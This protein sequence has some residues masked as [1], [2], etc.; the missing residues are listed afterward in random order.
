MK[1]YFLLG[2]L[3]GLILFGCNSEKPKKET[4]TRQTPKETVQQSSSTIKVG[5][6]P[7]ALFLTP[8]ENFLYVANV[9]DD[10][11]SV[12]DTKEEKVVN[13]IEGIKYPWG[14]SRLGNSNLVAVSG[15]DKQIVVIDFKE[16][17]IVK[18]KTFDNNLG[19]ITSTEDGK[20]IYVIETGKIK[21]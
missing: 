17:K 13:K 9:E 2:I 19:G 12:I 14:F 18:E 1:K 5:K 16:H 3:I 11:L 20:Y 7:D 21:R 4:K 15:Y 8:D 10:F 6:G